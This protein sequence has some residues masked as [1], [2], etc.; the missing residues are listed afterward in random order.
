VAYLSRPAVRAHSSWPAAPH[1]LMIGDRG[2]DA[3][4]LLDKRLTRRP[5]A[6]DVRRRNALATHPGITLDHTA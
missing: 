3:A 5:S 6:L 2:D 4:T 1:E